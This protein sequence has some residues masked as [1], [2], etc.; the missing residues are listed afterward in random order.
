MQISEK[1]FIEEYFKQ[2]EAAIAKI[3]RAYS[4][5]AEEFKDLMQEVLLQLWKARDSFGQQSKLSTWVYRVALNVCLSHI[6]KRKIRTVDLEHAHFTQWDSTVDD[7]NE[8]VAILYR[9]LKALS[10]EERAIMLLYL[11]EKKYEEISHIL[12]IS[13][14]NVGV[15]INRTKKKLKKIIESYGY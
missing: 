2:N 13:N 1:T 9:S 5:D 11:E 15:K 4:N 6:R 10:S 3:C 8:E 12:G 14:S 7:K